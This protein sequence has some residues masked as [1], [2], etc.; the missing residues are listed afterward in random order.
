MQS[1]S[2][3][4]TWRARHYA[5]FSPAAAAEFAYVKFTGSRVQTEHKNRIKQ[6][7]RK[8][9]VC[10]CV[11]VCACVCVCVR[12]CVCVTLKKSQEERKKKKKERKKEGKRGRESQG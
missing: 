3:G 8:V 7:Q 9:R 2:R 10:E 4:G 12:V 6:T 11:C 5:D 1:R